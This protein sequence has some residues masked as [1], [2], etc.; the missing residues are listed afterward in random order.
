MP[1]SRRFAF[2]ETLKNKRER[3]VQAEL[4]AP[5][6][7]AKRTAH[8]VHE[9][10]QL[11]GDT[12]SDNS[13]PE[14]YR[15][16]LPSPSNAYIAVH[17]VQMAA[18]FIDYN[19][20]IHDQMTGA[21]LHLNEHSFSGTNRSNCASPLFD[22][23]LASEAANGVPPAVLAGYDYSV[24][25]ESGNIGAPVAH[26]TTDETLLVRFGFDVIGSMIGNLGQDQFE[27]E[28]APTG[29][30]LQILS[31]NGNRPHAPTKPTTLRLVLG[32]HGTQQIAFGRGKTPLPFGSG[33]VRRLPWLFWIPGL[34]RYQNADHVGGYPV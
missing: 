24:D 19:L 10:G 28:V 30:P 2:T 32:A 31:R 3:L 26:W 21:A 1:V 7:L 17:S 34:L 27:Y 9:L 13:V 4:D 5:K 29:P 23:F 18:N 25:V 12:P 33:L 8:I 6:P 15:W 20:V 11:P 22:A 16:I 14:G